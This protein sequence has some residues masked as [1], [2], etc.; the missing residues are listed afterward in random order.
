M[1]LQEAVK[2]IL[3][4]NAPQGLALNLGYNNIGHVGAESLSQA[5]SSGKAPQGL[6]LNL[7]YNNIGHVGAES[8]SQALSSGK[9]PQGLAL[10]LW[11][12][13]IGNVGAA[14]LSQALSSG[15]A[16]QGLALNLWGNNIGNVGA[17]SLSQALSSGNAPQ[18]LKLDLG[19]NSIGADGINHL[20]GVINQ[21][22]CPVDLKIEGIPV[23]E[24]ALESQRVKNLV[25]TSHNLAQSRQMVN[26]NN[27]V[28]YREG[29]PH[30]LVSYIASFVHPK[31]LTIGKNVSCFFYVRNT[32]RTPLSAL[33][34]DI[35]K[36]GEALS[37]GDVESTIQSVIKTYLLNSALSPQAKETATKS[38]ISALQNIDK[39][40]AQ[41][42]VRN[43]L[44][45]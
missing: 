15:K 19:F 12:N 14:S 42:L 33:I 25:E 32:S 5:L 37:I 23:V 36:V 9:A 31:G 40:E 38:L 22:L 21:G 30:A 10:N 18:G 28:S 4:G 17:A 16:P 43:E 29:L 35:S 34:I 45:A 26:K 1:N 41:T 2:V 8:L 6:T 7:G 24:A 27:T 13:N 3:S 39:E 20:V 44:S 11:G